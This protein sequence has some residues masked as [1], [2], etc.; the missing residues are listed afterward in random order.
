ML[1]DD[2]LRGADVTI[3]NP[4]LDP[5]GRYAARAVELLKKASV[6]NRE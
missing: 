2:R 3:L 6:E 4:V 5:D 1:A